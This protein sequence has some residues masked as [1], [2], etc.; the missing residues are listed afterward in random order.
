MAT[1]KKVVVSGSAPQF[2][3]IQVDNLTTGQVVIGGG[4]AGNLSTTAINGTGN[5]V[6]TT[7]ASGLTHSGSFS[8]SFFGDG[9][10]LSGVAASF[11]ISQKTTLVPATD[12]VF[13]NDGTSKYATVS[14]FS[15]ASWVGVSGDITIDGTG[16]AAI[17]SGKVTS[18]MILNGT[19]LDADVNASAAIAYTKISFAGSNIVSGSGQISY[20][21]I[22]NI[23]AGI[24][25][26]AAQ[27]PALLPA[28]TISAS[29]QITGLTNANLSGTAG[30]TNAN[31]AN[32]AITIAG[33]STSLGGSITAAQI[34][35]GTGVISG[36]GQLPAGLV[37][38]SAQISYTGITNIPAGI[39]SAS[40]LSAPATQGQ[41]LLTTNGVAG[42]AVT[43]N[44][45]STSGT[46]TFSG[47][48]VTNDLTVN[49]NLAVNGTT[50]FI[51]TTNTYVKDQFLLLNS[52]SAAL[53]DSGIVAQYN[54][55]GS[56][57]ALFLE[58]TSAGTYGRWAMAYDLLGNVTSATPDEFVVSVKSAA[59]TA[60]LATAPTW[61]GASNGY[62][63]MYIN[64]SNSDIYIYA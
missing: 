58:S 12:K 4:T 2:S 36:S 40:V 11:P 39:V 1:W 13:I 19:I 29:A 28:G 8:G 30:I 26:G 9:S 18:T 38:G 57:S 3:A 49:G 55:A 23:P 22:T 51:N 61:G 35:A 59:G 10:G 37:S 53:A 42:T 6:A 32:S 54:A 31:L 33:T 50:T 60:A 52:G 34:L 43:I 63:N 16:V 17:G 27:I 64:S 24:V 44:S 46:P 5:I 45:L 62:G 15:S 7:D 21:G 20:T 14:Q 25:S 41:V 47:L 48:N 56:G